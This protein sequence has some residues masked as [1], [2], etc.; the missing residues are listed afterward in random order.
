VED[1]ALVVGSAVGNI[2]WAVEERLKNTTM[3]VDGIDVK[4][5]GIIQQLKYQDLLHYKY[6]VICCGA[7]KIAPITEQSNWDIERVIDACLTTPLQILRTWLEARMDGTVDNRPSA[8]VVLG[9]YGADH[10]LSNSV[11]YCAAKAGINMAVKCL[12]WDYGAHGFRLNV[13]NPHSVEDTPMTKEVI[14]QISMTKDLTESEALAYWKRML[15]L[16]N[17]LTRDEVAQTVEWILLD[18]PTAHLSGS[19]IELYGG[20]R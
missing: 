17:R 11:S 16:P 10:V 20:E 9:S 1:A 15:V 13:V 5:P 19:S 6:L 14:R 8:A 2:G 3:Q 12:A 7:M 18:C 4:G